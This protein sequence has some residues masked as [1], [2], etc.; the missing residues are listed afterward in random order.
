MANTD[1]YIDYAKLYEDGGVLVANSKIIKETIVAINDLLKDW[2]SWLG[3][4]SEAYVN[5]LKIMLNNLNLYS[6]EV[7]NVGIFLENISSEYSNAVSTCSKELNS[8]D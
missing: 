1:L 6:T 2:D 8:D 3:V 7:N 4:A 5:N